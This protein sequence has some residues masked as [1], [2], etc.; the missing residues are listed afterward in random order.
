MST[1]EPKRNS[2]KEDFLERPAR[3]ALRAK[4]GVLAG[5]RTPIEKAPTSFLELHGARAWAEKGPPKAEPAA[6][7]HVFPNAGRDQTWETV[8]AEIG[9]SADWLIW[10]NFRQPPPHDPAVIN[11]FLREYVG[12]TV[13]T[14][15][16]RNWTFENTAAGFIW[17]P[18]SRAERE[19][20]VVGIHDLL[21]EGMAA[22]AGD[23]GKLGGKKGEDR[24][25]TGIRPSDEVLYLNG[26][27]GYAETMR[28]LIRIEDYAALRGVT[29]SEDGD[30]SVYLVEPPEFPVEIDGADPHGYRPQGYG[31]GFRAAIAKWDAVVPADRAWD[32][33]RLGGDALVDRMYEYLERQMA[34]LM[35]STVSRVERAYPPAPAQRR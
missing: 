27:L 21:F 31:R 17:V 6:V 29:V 35:D 16:R 32:T 10:Y 23:F 30:L 22:L 7:R 28:A 18:R 25:N 2:V 34:A 14:S 8:A 3:D 33:R 12:A 19:S 9:K 13:A 11:W 26:L 24:Y 4:A 5:P 1:P 15:D 20:Q